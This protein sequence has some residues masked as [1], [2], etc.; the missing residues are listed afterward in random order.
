[1]NIVNK[2]KIFLSCPSDVIKEKKSLIRVI[3]ELN[4]T[5]GNEKNITLEL[6]QWQTH[7]VPSMGRPQEIIN[8]QMEPY[9]IY[10]GIMWK[11][12]GSSTDIY[13]SGTQEEFERA[14]KSWK[15]TN[16]PKI[17]FYFNKT[18]YALNNQEEIDQIK[19]VVEFQYKMRKLGLYREYNGQEE[20]ENMIREHFILT[21]MQY[22]F[23]MIDQDVSES[24][25]PYLLLRKQKLPI[26]IVDKLFDDTI[27]LLSMI[28]E[29]RDPYR[30]GHQ[31]Q[32]ASLAK[33]IAEN[34]KLDNKQIA[35]V[36]YAGLI[37]DIGYIYIPLEF[38]IKPSKLSE[39]E[40]DLIKVHPSYAYN[41]LKKT[42]YPWPIEQIIYQHHERI[43][44]TGYPNGLLG[45][46]ILVESKVL[47]V[48]DVLAA[49]SCH[50][51]YRPAPGIDYAL[52]HIIEEKGILFD[53]LVVEACA[54]LF[55]EDKQN[56]MKVIR[57]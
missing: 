51:V 39:S 2:I 26:E 10:L 49:M 32:V 28:V 31:R 27:I 50:R 11:R 48:A 17:M 40:Y 34:I 36:Y 37:H 52:K 9:D 41:L 38:I 45:D 55:H 43:N 12:F 54:K 30:A 42:K 19:H 25:N 8:E 3:N 24:N 7:V 46:K 20:F 1:M 57:Y 56:F 15:E 5:I 22:G 35:G 47:A 18:P 13:G 23:D 53:E 29:Q 16:H 4:R 6:C 14:Y 44:G 21:I 33:Y